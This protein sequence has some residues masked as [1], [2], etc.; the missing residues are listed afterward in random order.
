MKM[1]LTGACGSGALNRKTGERAYEV[2]CSKGRQKETRKQKSLGGITVSNY[3][4]TTATLP[5]NV[6]RL[7][8]TC[9]MRIN[10]SDETK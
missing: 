2:S 10:T 8:R 3:F 4:K 9:L 6:A 1:S 7:A 5:L